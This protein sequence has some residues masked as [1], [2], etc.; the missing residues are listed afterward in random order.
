MNEGCILQT[1]RCLPVTG[2]QADTLLPAAGL[3]Y[4]GGKPRAGEKNILSLKIISMARTRN[5]A[6]LKGASGKIGNAIVI[7]Q[8]SYGTVISAMPDMRRVKK[9]ALQKLK[10]G[11]FAEAVAYAQSIVRDPRKKAA[12]SK[13][14]KKGQ[15]VYHMAI[16]EYLKKQKAKGF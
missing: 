5:N 10:Q 12:Y 6:L 2:R 7:K 1:R 15:T 16:Q 4:K 8:Y 14:V 11:M 3:F 13:K 9:S